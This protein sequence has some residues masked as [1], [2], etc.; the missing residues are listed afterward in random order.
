M[1]DQSLKETFDLMERKRIKYGNKP[2]EITGQ[3]G[4]VVRQ[5]AKLC[6]LENME[7]EGIS[8]DDTVDMDESILDSRRDVF[9]YSIIGFELAFKK[10]I[11]F[12]FKKLI[13]EIL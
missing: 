5:I 6:R 3:T 9:N 4:L 7:K 1:F 10:D 8:R 12:S 13:K 2:L 11:K